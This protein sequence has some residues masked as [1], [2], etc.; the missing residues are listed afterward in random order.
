[1]YC[2][3]CS[4]L[5]WTGQNLKSVLEADTKE[6]YV[7]YDAQFHWLSDAH[8]SHSRLNTTEFIKM[9]SKFKLGLQTSLGDWPFVPKWQ[10]LN[11]YL[12]VALQTD[13]GRW[14]SSDDQYRAVCNTQQTDKGRYR[15]L[16]QISCNVQTSWVFTVVFLLYL[17]LA[18]AFGLEVI[19]CPHGS[20]FPA[21]RLEQIF[22]GYIL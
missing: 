17:N 9:L 4:S 18:L 13:G 6:V 2:V 5:G 8:W 10:K 16:G 15:D 12:L 3:C 19:F 14:V 20:A 1:M 11:V 22:L 21:G 7:L